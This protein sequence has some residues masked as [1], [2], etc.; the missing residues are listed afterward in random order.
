VFTHHYN[1]LTRLIRSLKEF[2]TVAWSR[3]IKG[4]SRRMIYQ[5][6]WVSE[7]VHRMTF[8]DFTCIRRKEFRAGEGEAHIAYDIQPSALGIYSTHFVVCIKSLSSW[9]VDDINE[10]Q[11]RATRIN[12]ANILNYPHQN[13]SCFSY[14][15]FDHL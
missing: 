11:T 5:A 2:L 12:I 9:L 6:L 3:I 8:I 15:S 7:V 4:P 10:C 1:M 13:D 14:V